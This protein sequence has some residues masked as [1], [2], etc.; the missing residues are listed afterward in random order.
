MS[1]C[2]K[3][4][5]FSQRVSRDAEPFPWQAPHG[6]EVLGKFFLHDLQGWHDGPSACLM[7]R[8]LSLNHLGKIIDF[9]LTCAIFKS[10]HTRLCSSVRSKRCEYQLEL[11]YQLITS[12]LPTV[13]EFSH[14]INWMMIF[15][16]HFFFLCRHY[17]EGASIVAQLA[18]TWKQPRCLLTREWIKK[19]W[20]I[21]T[22]EY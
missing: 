3:S 1:E 6:A 7:P 19:L 9:Q 14:Y 12:N 11:I 5:C 10:K 20:Y 17:N 13:R 22:M 18:R 4:K 21:Y 2:L 16:E 8:W 15:R